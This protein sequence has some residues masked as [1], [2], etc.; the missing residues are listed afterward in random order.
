MRARDAKDIVMLYVNE[1]H[2]LERQIAVHTRVRSDA[3]DLVQ[4]IF[5]KLWERAGA[6]A[7]N[8]SAFLSRSARNA[9]IDYMRKERVRRDY[10]K[11]AFGRADL[12]HDPNFAQ[13]SARQSLAAVSRAISALPD[14][15]RSIF[16]MNRVDGLT[17][18]EIA[19]NC[20]ISE[21]AV[22]KQ[23]A[24]ALA[25]CAQALEPDEGLRSADDL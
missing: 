4:D 21:R 16:L 3:R 19:E 1:R 15:T 25:A 13:L 24:R 17:F 7:T 22:A 6:A 18:R 11:E 9:S 23:M 12:E 20:A 5:L 8:P 2:R 10:Q 14:R